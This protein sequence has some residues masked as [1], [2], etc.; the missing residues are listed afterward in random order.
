MQAKDEHCGK[1]I[2]FIKYGTVHGD[3]ELMDQMKHSKD[4]Y[5]VN[6]GILFHKWFQKGSHEHLQVIVS[7]VVVGKVL[8]GNHDATTAGHPGFMRTYTRIRE[9]YFLPTMKKDVAIHMPSM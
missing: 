6:D 2:D 1:W 4:I 7:K 9:K 3:K 8:V 5:V